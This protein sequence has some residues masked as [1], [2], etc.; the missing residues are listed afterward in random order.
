MR[1]RAIEIDNFRS[2]KR[3][4]WYPQPGINCLVGPGDSGKSTVLEAIDLCLGARRNWQFTDADFYELDS[5][6]PIRI[7]VTIGELEAS[8]KKLEGFGHL[9]RSF[10]AKANKI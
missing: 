7:A 2:I 9:V 4:L 5:A 6:N 10:D 8:F 1:I 3:C